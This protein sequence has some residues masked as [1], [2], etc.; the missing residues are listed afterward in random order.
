[1]TRYC[2][3]SCQPPEIP[4]FRWYPVART[5]PLAGLSGWVNG[6]GFPT[7]T[8]GAKRFLNGNEPGWFGNQRM[9]TDPVRHENMGENLWKNVYPPAGS[10]G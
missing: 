4:A 10:G 8:V 9:G 7:R 2:R 5:R 6:G 1:M 3:G